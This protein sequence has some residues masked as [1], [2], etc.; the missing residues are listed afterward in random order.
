MARR[1]KAERPGPSGFLVVDKPP[2][3]TSHDAVEAAR[4]WFRTRRVGHLGTLD[5][6]ATGVLPLAVRQATKLIPYVPAG[7]KIYRGTIRL[8]VSTDT[9]DGDGQVTAR[10]EGELPDEAAVRD[11]LA[12]F[13]GEI[14]QVPPMYS[15]VKHA[16]TPLYRIARRGEEVERAP[17]KVRIDRFSLLAYAPPDADVE[18]VC[19][20]GT[21]VRVLAADVGARLGCG[22]FLK[23]LCRV[24]S[25][26][27]ELAQAVTPEVLAEEA[28]TGK[29]EAHLLRPAAV[30]GMTTLRLTPEEARRVRH[31]GALPSG[32][33]PRPVGTQ[34]AALDPT[35][36][37]LA[38][39][40][41]APDRQLRPQRVLAGE[42]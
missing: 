21:Y 11:A 15:A 40:E 25:G 19:S 16:G 36:E 23:G 22:A 28:E 14:E 39:L 18:V 4:R 9:Y 20:P 17:R 12:A 8:G 5:P 35:G 26:P 13:V 10:H 41:V 38:I 34:V 33:A 30:L 31:G 27:F 24:R 6:Q 32:G 1:R 37:L 2:G 3:W 29:L 7:P 42:G